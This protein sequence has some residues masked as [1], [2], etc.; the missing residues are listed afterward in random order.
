MI[1]AGMVTI[2]LFFFARWRPRLQWSWKAFRELSR[3]G[4]GLTGFNIINYWGRSIDKLL[5]GNSLGA[6]PLGLYSRAYALMLLPLSQAAN[7]LIPVMF[8]AMT[9]FQNDKA[10]VRRV[11][12]QVISVLTFI[13]F[14]LML[15][16]IAV[17]EPFVVAFF[18]LQ[19]APA[20]PLIQILAVVGMTQTLCNPVGLIYTSQ[21]RTDWMFWWGSAV[22]GFWSCRSSSAFPTAPL[23]H[24]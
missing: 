7:I 22:R 9:A 17:A 4:A 2:L 10:R 1:N 24:R 21:G 13:A 14:P 11:F 3:Y 8:P 20:V 18:G 12:L 5:V 15:G 23:R 16:L 6:S 19:W